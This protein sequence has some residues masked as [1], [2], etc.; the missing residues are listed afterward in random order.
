MTDGGINFR[1]LVD[2]WGHPYYVRYSIEWEYGDKT[3]I[4]YQ[5]DSKV[6]TGTLVTRKLARIRI[7]SSGSD[8]RANTSDD[9]AVASFSRDISEQSGKDLVPEPVSSEPLSGNTGAI[10]GIV[11][12]ITGAVMPNAAVVA[13]LRQTGQAFTATSDSDGAYIIRNIPPGVYDVSVSAPGFRTTEVRGVP[14]HSTSITALNVVLDV[15]AMTQ[16]VEVTVQAAKVETATSSIV[17]GKAAEGT[18][19]RVHEETFTPRLREYFPELS[20]GLLPSSPTP[21]VA[22]G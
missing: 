4:T 7:M 9:F 10:N 22:P 2:P 21:G 6:Q 19:V 5:P 14:V 17:A 18:K 11:T 20:S 12:D 16:T 1:G 8:G 15:G 3:R 13:T